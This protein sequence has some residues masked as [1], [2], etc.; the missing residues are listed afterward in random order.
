[1]AGATGGQGRE[2][3]DAR[4]AQADVAAVEDELVGGAREPD[5]V[6]V[7]DGPLPSRRQRQALAVGGEE[8]V[9]LVLPGDVDPPRTSRLD[10][11]GR[12]GRAL[13]VIAQV[14]RR[15]E[16]PP[17]VAAVQVEDLLAVEDVVLP[18]DVDVV[19]RGVQRRLVARLLPA[20]QDDRPGERRPGV[21]APEVEEV[22]ALLP[23]VGVPADHD[24]DETALR[25]H[26]RRGVH[27]R[28]GQVHGRREG[29]PAVGAADVAGALRGGIAE[30]DVDGAAGDVDGRLVLLA[31]RV[32][33]VRLG[34]EGRA[35]VRAPDEVDLVLQARGILGDVVAGLVDDGDQVAVRRDVR[36]A[37]VEVRRVRDVDGNGERPALVRAARVHHVVAVGLVAAGV[38]VAGAVDRVVLPDHVD[39][40]ATGIQVALAGVPL[41]RPPGGVEHVQADR[42]REAPATVRA[43]PVEHLARVVG[44]GVED[45]VHRAA[46]RLHVGDRHVLVHVVELSRDEAAPGVVAAEVGE[47]PRGVARADVRVHRGHDP[48]AARREASRDDPHQRVAMPSWSPH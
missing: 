42:A 37:V 32:R 36:V 28:A 4:A 24:V 10:R 45:R 6:L 1:M 33:Q 30:H 2:G 14:A 18:H 22:M 11:D 38:G 44:V 7:R 35:T 12:V 23:V 47:G 26:A 40:V 20:E 41:A 17:A 27:I 21:G 46:R 3:V 25:E 5:H 9:R 19:P 8:E 31:D 15:A 39:G 16:A 13:V 34:A 48:E 29:G 43:A